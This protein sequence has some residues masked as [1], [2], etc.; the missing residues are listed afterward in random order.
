MN[1]TVHPKPPHRCHRAVAD[2]LVFAC[3]L[4]HELDL[5]HDDSHFDPLAGI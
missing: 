3:A 1:T 4:V 2:L 5:A